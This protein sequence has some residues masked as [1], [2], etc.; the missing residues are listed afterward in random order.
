MEPFARVQGDNGCCFNHGNITSL[1]CDCAYGYGPES[2][3]DP[4]ALYAIHMPSNCTLSC[5][6]G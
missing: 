2:I 3:A 5:Y 1:G 6:L 4:G